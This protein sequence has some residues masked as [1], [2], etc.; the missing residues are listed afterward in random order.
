MAFS[1]PTANA[2]PQPLKKDWGKLD[3][4]MALKI[5]APPASALRLP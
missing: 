3:L 5:L 2:F 1:M 4:D